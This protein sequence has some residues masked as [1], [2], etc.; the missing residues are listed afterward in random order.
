MIAVSSTPFHKILRGAYLQKLCNSYQR[1]HV[2]RTTAKPL[3]AVESTWD[4]DDQPHRLRQIR[5][6]RSAPCR[7]NGALL[8]E[9]IHHLQFDYCASSMPIPC[10]EP[11]RIQ[12]GRS[13]RHAYQSLQAVDQH[14]SES[15]RHGAEMPEQPATSPV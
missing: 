12:S 4:A 9:A 1:T 7:S 13:C 2:H 10:G 14:A 5:N 6:S 15:L 8:A 3:Q 11:K